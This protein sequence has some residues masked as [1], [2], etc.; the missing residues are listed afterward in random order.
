MLVSKCSSGIG[1]QPRRVSGR[2]GLQSPV[3]CRAQ[4]NTPP[5]GEQTFPI[6]TLVKTFIKTLVKPGLCIVLYEHGASLHAACPCQAAGAV[7]PG[8][9]QEVFLEPG[10][11]LPKQSAK[12]MVKTSL[13]AI[14]MTKVT[15][16]LQCRRRREHKPWTPS[17]P[18][19][20]MGSNPCSPH[21][22]KRKRSRRRRPRQ[23]GRGPFTLK[24]QHRHHM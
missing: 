16:C 1:Q 6:T 13:L 24:P 10:Q 12:V 4:A 18:Y 15:P 11:E 22:P 14:C 2:G 9:Q 23:Q 8:E 7:R 21:P 3:C 17:P 5:R 20:Q 19:K